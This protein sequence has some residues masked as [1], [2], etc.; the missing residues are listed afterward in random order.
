LVIA[1]LFLGTFFANAG[2]WM[3]TNDDFLGAAVDQASAGYSDAES[4]HVIMDGTRLNGR[5]VIVYR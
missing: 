3:L 4:T 2:S 1:S 5:A